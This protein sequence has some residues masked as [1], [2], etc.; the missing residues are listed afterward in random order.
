MLRLLRQPHN[1]GAKDGRFEM[2]LAMPER[3]VGVER[4]AGGRIA[5]PQ[6]LASAGAADGRCCSR[7]AAAPSPRGCAPPASRDDFDDYYYFLS[8]LG[9]KSESV[10]TRLLVLI[11]RDAAPCRR[12]AAGR[13]RRFAHQA[14]RARRS[15][16]PTSTATRRRAQPTR[17]I[18]Y[19]H[20]WVT[21]SLAVRHPLWGALVVAAAGDALCSSAARWPRFRKHRRWKFRTKLELGGD[22]GGVDRSAGENSGENP[23]GGRGWILYEK[24][25]FLKRVLAEGVVVVG[26]VAGKTPRSA[27]CHPDPSAASGVV[28]AAP[29]KYGPNRVS[30]AKRAGHRRGWHSVE[31]PCSTASGPSRRARRS[32]RP[33]ARLSLRDPRRLGETG[34]WLVRS[35]LYPPPCQRGGDSRNVCRPCHHRTGLSRRQGSLGAGQ[36]QVAYLAQRSRVSARP[37][38]AYAG[39]VVGLEPQSRR[40]ASIEATRPGTTPEASRFARQPSQSPGQQIIQHTNYPP[41]PPHSGCHEKSFNW[42]NASWC[43]PHNVIQFSKSADVRRKA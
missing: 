37:V 22:A 2:S 4:L 9:R 26:S 30:L 25:P 33:T 17:S 24:L 35:V 21:L 27:I 11:L 13:D 7:T 12:T 3:V 15:K 14:L 1:G 40:T 23:V 10:A 34:A 19:G 32:W 43:W 31:C 18:M 38:D 42:P 20:I 5:R 29:R 8:S 28:A 41:L 16:G 6:P 39:R 36:Q